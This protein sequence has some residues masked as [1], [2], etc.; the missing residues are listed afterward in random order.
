MAAI[1]GITSQSLLGGLTSAK[2]TQPAGG[3]AFADVLRDVLTADANAQAEAAQATS[4][5]A[6]GK[7]QDLHTVGLAVSKADLQFRLVLEIRNR[8]TEAYQEVMRTQ[9]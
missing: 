7:A 9:V 5:F 6:T 4:D 3:A 1:Q 8:L 2:P